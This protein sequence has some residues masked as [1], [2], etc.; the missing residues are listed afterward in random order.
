MQGGQDWQAGGAR[1]TQAGE[2]PTS[3]NLFQQL[4]ILWK[5]TDFIENKLHFSFSIF[6]VR[7]SIF[8]IRHWLS[9]LRISIYELRFPNITIELI[10]GLIQPIRHKG[11]DGIRGAVED[12]R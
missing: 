6:D 12:G 1:Q 5:R 8:D 10:H 2:F 9:E 4:L 11:Q 3:L 7:C